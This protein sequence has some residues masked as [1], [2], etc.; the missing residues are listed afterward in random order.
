[1]ATNLCTSNVT[2]TRLVEQMRLEP[3]SNFDT[4]HIATLYAA[5]WRTAPYYENW[6]IEAAINAVESLAEGFTVATISQRIVGF[7]ASTSWDEVARFK[8]DFKPATNQIS[9]NGY[10]PSKVK[11]L[12]ELAIMPEFRGKHLGSVLLDGFL[13]QAQ[14]HSDAIVLRTHGCEATNPATRLYHN[15][16][17]QILRDS[18]NQAITTTVTFPRVINT[19][20]ES[21]HRPFY[22]LDLRHRHRHQ[23][24]E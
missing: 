10:S 18:K 23:F 22:V 9:L 15:F 13:K 14:S 7:I 20:H 21:D 17:F 11:Y 12:A 6:S 16:G 5:T 3:L 8:V 4:K 1:M 2:N 24:K 19:A